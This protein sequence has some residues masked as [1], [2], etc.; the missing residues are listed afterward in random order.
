MKKTTSAVQ[1]QEDFWSNNPCGALGSLSNKRRQRY[2]MEP[3]VPI[4]LREKVAND[5]PKKYLEIGCGQGV[6]TYYMCSLINKA[7]EYIAL[8]YSPESLKVASQ[9]LAEATNEGIKVVP[10][11][12]EGSALDL[13]F[14]DNS[15]DAIYSMGVL[16]HT[17]DPQLAI[18]EAHR[19]LKNGGQAYICLYRK[20]SL[21]LLFAKTLRGIQ[22]VVDFVTRQDRIFYKLLKKNYAANSLGTMLLEC[23]GVPFM[24]CYRERE[25][26]KM[27]SN[28][29]TIS[30]KK[31]GYNLPNIKPGGNGENFWGW[32]WVIEAKK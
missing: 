9:H 15:I 20:Y 12:I 10:K 32:F 22:H 31:V 28:F 7:S 11:F 29:N 21:K 26:K 17:P 3:W 25:L 13:P 16:H 30:I 18:N 19:V 2:D 27:F 6:D 24:Y 14:E 1:Q 23:F 8:D 4:L 5:T